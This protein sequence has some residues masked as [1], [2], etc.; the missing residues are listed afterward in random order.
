MTGARQTLETGMLSFAR[1]IQVSESLFF[2][3]RSS[4][5]EYREPVIVREKGVRGQS[6]EFKTDNP[7]K[8]NP[9][10]VEAAAVPPGCN[11]V[12]L[13]FTVSF[14][15][16]VRKPFACGDAAVG[17]AYED[18]VGKYAGKGGFELLACL[19]L[20]NIANGRFAWRNRWQADEM[21]VHIETDGRSLTF[22]PTILDLD[23]PANLAELQAAAVDGDASSISAM[24]TDIAAGLCGNADARVCLKVAWM[25]AMDEGQEVFPS[26]EYIRDV[27][28]SNAPSRVLAKLPTTWN[29][30]TVQQASI[31][32]QKIGAA[33][34][35]IDTWHGHQGYGAIAINPYGGVQET[36]AVLRVE[37]KRGGEDS[38]SSFYALR[39]R[40][41]ELF[42]AIEGAEDAA[43]MPS[44]VHFVVANLVRGGVFGQ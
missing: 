22:D 39:S 3:T 23:K 21:K 38:A 9:Q 40:P 43:A 30:R 13:G 34:R 27:G 12:E 1:S 10:V 2:G 41:D 28:R 20:W 29:G 18:L 16:H 25:A 7:G 31:H 44:D 32:S 15:P 35:H 26:Q 19:Y 36:G 11:G 37:G 8:S 5:A 17:K 42:A 14:L 4:E 24:I 6:S 33:I